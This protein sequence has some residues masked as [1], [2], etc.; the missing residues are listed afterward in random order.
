VSRDI[1]NI[2]YLSKLL[3]MHGLQ[4]DPYQ[5]KEKSIRGKFKH[6]KTVQ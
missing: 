4:G 2:Q 6:V 5:R 3:Y 1:A